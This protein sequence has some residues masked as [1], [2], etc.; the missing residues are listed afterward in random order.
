MEAFVALLGRKTIQSATRLMDL[1][2]LTGRLVG[3]ALP[4]PRSGGP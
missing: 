3:V 4:L 1:C 2:A